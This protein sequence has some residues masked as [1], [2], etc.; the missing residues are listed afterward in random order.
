MRIARNLDRLEMPHFRKFQQLLEARWFGEN[1]VPHR[2]FCYI[3]PSGRSVI[4]LCGCTHK[5]RRYNPTNAYD[6]AIE[7]RNEIGE[8]RAGTHEFDF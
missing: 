8:G 6:T 4:F 1:R 7:R 3:A 2:I 5:D